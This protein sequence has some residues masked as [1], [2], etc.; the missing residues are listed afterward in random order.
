MHSEHRRLSYHQQHQIKLLDEEWKEKL[1]PLE[2]KVEG[3]RESIRSIKEERKQRSNA[4]QH[5][6]FDQYNFL[7]GKG[8]AKSLIDIF[9]E[10]ADKLPPSAAGD[11]AA[12]KL[13]QY[14]FENK[15]KPICMGEF[16]WGKVTTAEVRKHGYF[17]PS[18]RGKC[19]PIL[20]H[21]LQGLQVDSNP[22][23]DD[24]SES[25]TIEVIYE[26]QA[27]AIIVKPAEFLSVPGKS[28]DDSVYL[29]MKLRYP[30]A[31]GP[32]IVHR[33][34]MSTS[35]LMIIAKTKESHKKLQREFIRKKVVKRY[36][37]ILDGL[38]DSDQGEV[39]LPI[40]VDL[41]N[42]PRQLVCYEYGKMAHTRYEVV[43]VKNSKTKVHFFPITGRTHQLRVHSAHNS[44]LKTPILGDDLYGKTANRLHLHAAYIKFQHPLTGAFVEFHSQ[45][46]FSGF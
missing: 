22:M 12:P 27:L 10:V 23:L 9:Q 33:L 13:L 6:L 3:Y 2:A 15:L 20:G 39:I 16:W 25:K 24:L 11:C 43:A 21:M 31:T 46:D 41:N 1:H 7:N 38:L 5:R 18:C 34:D 40:R 44:G 37:A 14:A 26:D 28:I 17:Y 35:G 45:D 29:R 19:E 8:N 4:L 32:L 30:A 36:T 42:R